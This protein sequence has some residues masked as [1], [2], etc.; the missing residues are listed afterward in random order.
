MTNYKEK[1]IKYKLKYLNLVGGVQSIEIDLKNCT[2]F[3]L[4]TNNNLKNGEFFTLKS[5]QEKR[6]EF[7]RLQ[8]SCQTI[9]TIIDKD[10]KETC[11]L[12]LNLVDKVNDYVE[13]IRI[14]ENSPYNESKLVKEINGIFDSFNFKFNLNNL[15]NFLLN[16]F[17]FL[18]AIITK[19]KSLFEKILLNREYDSIFEVDFRIHKYFSINFEDYSIF[20]NEK[21]ISCPIFFK[22]FRQRYIEIVKLTDQLR[23]SFYNNLEKFIADSDFSKFYKES[24][25]LNK[26]FN[27]YETR[28]RAGIRIICLEIGELISAEV[29]VDFLSNLKILNN[30]IDNKSNG[31]EKILKSFESL[32][33]SFI[34]DTKCSKKNKKKIYNLLLKISNILKFLSTPDL[35][36]NIDKQMVEAFNSLSL[37]EQVAVKVKG[38]SYNLQKLNEEI[39]KLEDKLQ[40]CVKSDHSIKKAFQEFRNNNFANIDNTVIG[41]FKNLNVE[42]DKFKESICILNQD[43]LTKAE[44]KNILDKIRILLKIPEKDISNEIKESKSKSN[45]TEKSIF[46][47]LFNK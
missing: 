44:L 2:K 18:Q 27:E 36:Q 43:K 1:Y 40:K 15:I 34:I 23:K 38:Q 3:S 39:N 16:F 14:F 12:L 13:F 5:F 42:V 30:I 41:S 21:F 28:L 9:N 6:K 24:E 17:I 20:H 46:S 47:R 29:C 45:S 25:D 37:I 10:Y 7:L 8:T 22:V 4:F 11:I 32:V 31:N 35:Q 33:A 26:I 19:I